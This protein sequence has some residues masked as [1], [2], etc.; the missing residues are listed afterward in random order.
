MINSCFA[1][2]DNR[3]SNLLRLL[4]EGAIHTNQTS[5]VLSCQGKSQHQPVCNFQQL[6]GVLF[7][8]KVEQIHTT[9]IHIS[10]LIHYHYLT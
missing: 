10:P 9:I 8:S 5:Q 1:G 7:E 6:T 4:Q 2:S 3:K